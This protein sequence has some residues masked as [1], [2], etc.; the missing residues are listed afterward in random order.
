M[1]AGPREL[2][3]E[4]AGLAVYAAEILERINGTRDCIKPSGICLQSPIPVEVWGEL[5][6]VRPKVYAEL[7]VTVHALTARHVD[8]RIR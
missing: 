5:R 4:L 8:K 6:E 3:A 1:H 2:L 7:R